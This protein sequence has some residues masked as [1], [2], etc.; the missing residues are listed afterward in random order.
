MLYHII[1]ELLRAALAPPGS[2]ELLNDPTDADSILRAAG[3]LE[4]QGEWESALHLYAR[5][6]ELLHGRQDGVYA[7]N[8]LKEVQEKL[9]RLKER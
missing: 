7:E 6:A 2:S 5:A 8:C 3:M 1:F 4:Q 9:N